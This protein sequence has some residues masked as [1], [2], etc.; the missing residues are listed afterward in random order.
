M[1]EWRQLEACEQKR[2]EG[3]DRR[4]GQGATSEPGICSTKDCCALTRCGLFPQP[5]MQLCFSSPHSAAGPTPPAPPPAAAAAA[6]GLRFRPLS[7]YGPSGVAAVQTRA[8][9]PSGHSPSQ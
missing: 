5:G 3:E 7:V 2:E 1:G 6:H 9:E 4:D 8:S